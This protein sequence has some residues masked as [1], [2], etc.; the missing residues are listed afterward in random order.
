MWALV[1]SAIS[2]HKKYRAL[3]MSGLTEPTLVML[4]QQIH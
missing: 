2:L 3:T 1:T 4:R